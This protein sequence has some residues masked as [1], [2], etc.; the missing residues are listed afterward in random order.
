MSSLR[1]SFETKEAYNKY[2]RKAKWKC[3]GI[4]DLDKAE[5]V[6][7]NKTH[8]KICDATKNLVLDH[9]HDSKEVRGILCRKCNLAL[10]VFKN[11]QLLIKAIDYYE[12]VVY[13][14]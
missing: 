8:C 10:G 13:N 1:N 2:M 12:N 9:C 11:K 3:R 4:V 7:E 5:A 6:Y 14:G